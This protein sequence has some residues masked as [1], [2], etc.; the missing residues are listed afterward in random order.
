[1]FSIRLSA[2]TDEDYNIFIVNNFLTGDFGTMKF[3]QKYGYVQGNETIYDRDR[4]FAHELGHGVAG[5]E[6]T[7]NG[8]TNPDDPI[9]DDKNIMMPSILAAP[10]AFRLRKYQWDL[11][12]PTVVE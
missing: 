4:T 11:L 3:N 7:D 2:E 10:N 9:D 5:L 1:M 12:N 8:V 6:H